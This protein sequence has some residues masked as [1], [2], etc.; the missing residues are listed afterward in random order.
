VTDPA[1]PAPLLKVRI[2]VD[3]WNFTLACKTLT[4]GFRFDWSNIGPLF[5][6]EAAMMVNQAIPHSYEAMHV[7]GSYSPHQ[8]A[9]M[10]FK[11]WLT[12]T[13]DKQPGVIVE[14][15]ERKLK[16]SAPKCPKCY[17][18]AMLCVSCGADM[19]G[20]EEKGV[21]TRIV[22]DMMS[23][24]WSGGYDVAVLVSADRDFVPVAEELQKRGFKVIHAQINGAG[25]DLARH[26]WGVLKVD[27]LMSRFEAPAKKGDPT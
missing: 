21:D 16:K 27:T 25:Q 20:T 10:K 13:L 19:R 7:Y 17:E 11:H 24:A 6:A 9:D 3:Y 15:V 12:S 18:A 4:P 23:L 2:F 1:A 5:A 22:T 8:G 14:A 26:C